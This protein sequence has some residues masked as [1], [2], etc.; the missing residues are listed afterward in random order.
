MTISTLIF[1]GPPRWGP[2]SDNLDDFRHLSAAA[3]AGVMHHPD[4]LPQG[5]AR[6]GQRATAAR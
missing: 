4:A 6:L 1:T 2:M 3:L 5:D